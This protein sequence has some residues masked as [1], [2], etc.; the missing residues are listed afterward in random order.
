MIEKIRKY[1]IKNNIIDSNCRLNVDFLGGEAREFSLEKIP[2]NPIIEEYANG[3]SYRELQFRL[4]SKEYYGAGVIQN[5]ENS[6]IYEKIYDIIEKNNR[7]GILPDIEGIESIE[8]LNNGGI[9]Y[10][11]ANTAKYAIQ[12]RITYY[13]EV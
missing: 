11:E 1:L 7:D 10:T 13:K 12:M 5:L 8:C 3:G 6:E 9:D 4:A 2:N